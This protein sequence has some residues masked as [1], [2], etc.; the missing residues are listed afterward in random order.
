MGT[1]KGKQLNYKAVL[2][3]QFHIVKLLPKKGKPVQPSALKI[4]GKQRTTT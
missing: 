1:R 3:K 4:G 2:E